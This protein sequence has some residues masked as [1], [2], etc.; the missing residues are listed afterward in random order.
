VPKIDGYLE[1]LGIGLVNKDYRKAKF[2][3]RKDPARK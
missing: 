2:A 3:N 1:E